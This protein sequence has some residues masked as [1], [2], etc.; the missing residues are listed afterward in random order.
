MTYYGHYHIGR[1][2]FSRSQKEGKK[3]ILDFKEYLRQRAFWEGFD[4]YW[5][6]SLSFDSL[7]EQLR[8]KHWEQNSGPV[9]WDLQKEKKGAKINF[10]I[11]LCT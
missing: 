8:D 4:K 7:V 6:L 9:T 11:F 10:I 5:H 1:F 3:L 2:S